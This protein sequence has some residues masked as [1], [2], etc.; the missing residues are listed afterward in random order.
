MDILILIFGIVICSFLSWH[1]LVST[2]SMN[3]LDRIKSLFNSKQ[4]YNH[5]ESDKFKNSKFRICFWVN[6]ILLFFFNISQ[7]LYIF[8]CGAK[9]ASQDYLG[10]G[11]YTMLLILFTLLALAW[12]MFLFKDFKE[13]NHNHRF[14]IL[15]IGVSFI[16]LYMTANNLDFLPNRVKYLFNIF[17]LAM[18]IFVVNEIQQLKEK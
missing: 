15:Y 14:I 7:I 16:A 13:M 1:W 12:W 9:L 3:L 4:K 11:F 2:D 18:P 6:A 8:V 10:L 5:F 17:Y